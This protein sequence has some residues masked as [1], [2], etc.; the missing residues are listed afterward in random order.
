MV[1]VHEQG[2]TLRGQ[3]P[4]TAGKRC[5]V[6]AAPEKFISEKCNKTGKTG[7]ESVGL[8]NFLEIFLDIAPAKFCP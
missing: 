4:Q 8:Q 1:L 3:V 7:P 5:A 6:V 2:R